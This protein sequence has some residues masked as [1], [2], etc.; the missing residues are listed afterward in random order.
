MQDR[1]KHIKEY[2]DPWNVT[3]SVIIPCKNERGNIEAAVKRIP[4]MGRS[5]EIIFCDDRSTDG[6][7]EEIGEMQAAY[8][9]R[10]IRLVPGPDR[11]KG[12]NVMAGF[13]ASGGDILMILDGD[14]AVMPEELPLFFNALVEK[15][16]DFINGTRFV[17]PMRRGSMKTINKIG[18][19]VFSVILSVLLR[20]KITDTLCGTK[21][22]WKS[23]WER[24]ALL[25]GAW[26]VRD[27]WGDFE[28]LLGAANSGLK[29]AEV[30][31]HY[32][33]RAHGES[34]MVNEFLHGFLMLRMC[35]SALFKLR[36]RDNEKIDLPDD[37]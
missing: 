15:R 14:L 29:V 10:N 37:S 31:V 22:M 18:N 2:A 5:T 8:P 6:T 33:K 28:L 34:K 36:A 24:I 35:W 26:G 1:V 23:D 19:K 12:E 20:R 27:E 7:V 21:A 3:V 13:R 9:G 32:Q 25:H 4:P 17:H 16:G 30:P 11:G